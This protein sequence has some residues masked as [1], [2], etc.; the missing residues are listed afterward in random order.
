MRR[1]LTV[2]LGCVLVAGAVSAQARAAVESA[3]GF[4]Y[5]S[6]QGTV[7]AGKSKTIKAPC[8]GKTQVWWGGMT[9]GVFSQ[10]AAITGVPYDDGDKG[11]EPDNGWMS[12]IRN[13]SNSRHS[14]TARAVCTK[15]L[16]PV[17]RTVE[18]KADAKELS[19][20]QVSCPGDKVPVGGGLTGKVFLNST[21]PVSGAWLMFAE[22]RKEKREPV[23]A[24]GVCIE[25]SL[26][27]SV[28]Q[29]TTTAFP[30]GAGGASQPCEDSSDIGI[31]GGTSN[32]G[33]YR[34]IVVTSML[35]GADLGASIL[36]HNH[37]ASTLSATTYTLCFDTSV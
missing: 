28:R 37:S 10:D 29:F 32:N 11:R 20:F 24:I 21:F 5:V 19:T 2:V 34:T 15:R 9:S 31:G 18:M 35:A 6:V 12:T 14:A 33:A 7:K 23:R 8:P 1:E 36:F 26:R 25:P 13:G 17:Y 30:S 27:L 4:D 16:E 3:G 22:N